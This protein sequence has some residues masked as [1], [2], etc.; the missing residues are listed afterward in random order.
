[1][2]F[3][4]RD[5]ATTALA[6]FG[7]IIVDAKFYNFGWAVIDSWRS[8]TA[9]IGLTGTLMAAVSGFDVTNRSTLN[10]IEM[11][12][13]VAAIGTGMAGLAFGSETL[14]YALSGL[15]FIL[16]AF[17]I[18]RHAWHSA[19]GEDPASPYDHPAAIH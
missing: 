3:T 17:E 11:I 7:G 4:W 10:I 8:A 16:W 1:M 13:G 12:L 9:V 5:L 6:I 2:R 14:F 19:M 15:L 18:A